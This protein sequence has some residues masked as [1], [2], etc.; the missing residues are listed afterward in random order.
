MAIHT[1]IVKYLA[2]TAITYV[3]AVTVTIDRSMHSWAYGVHADHGAYNIS[4][5][6]AVQDKFDSKNLSFD[7][8]ILK[9]LKEGLAVL[10][11]ARLQT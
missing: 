11:S 9:T 3:S 10:P 7:S 5:I 4:R 8:L 1:L 6:D 2:V